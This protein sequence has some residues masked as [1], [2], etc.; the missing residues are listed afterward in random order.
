[1]LRH[2]P[3]GSRCSDAARGRN[4]SATEGYR[5]GRRLRDRAHQGSRRTHLRGMRQLLLKRVAGLRHLQDTGAE[6]RCGRQ[7]GEEPVIDRLKLAGFVAAALL[8]VQAVALANSPARTEEFSGNDLR[9]IRLGMAVA[10]LEESGY[11]DFACAADP[12]HTLAGWT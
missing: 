12:K 6:A 9:D 8:A 5:I 11:V 2:E 3:P 4:V 7:H 1:M 10:E